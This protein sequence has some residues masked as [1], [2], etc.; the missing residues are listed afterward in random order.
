MDDFLEFRMHL[1]MLDLLLVNGLKGHQMA[2]GKFSG[3]QPSFSFGRA[4]RQSICKCL[5]II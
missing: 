1:V 3:I 2:L 4:G 5:N